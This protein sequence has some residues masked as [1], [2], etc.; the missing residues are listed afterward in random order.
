M[1]KPELLLKLDELMRLQ[2]GTLK[3][4]EELGTL[5]W[6][7]ITVMGYIAMLSGMKKR[8]SGKDVTS[9]KSVGQLLALAGVTE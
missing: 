9:C 7:S 5:N 8:V 1:T 4:D 3:G 2:P 6:D